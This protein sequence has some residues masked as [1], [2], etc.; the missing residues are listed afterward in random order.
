[1]SAPQR[2]EFD[3]QSNFRNPPE[4]TC[5]VCGQAG[6]T[7]T[8]A[9]IGGTKCTGMA[10]RKG[11]AVGGWVCSVTC[12]QVKA[13]LDHRACELD[14]RAAAAMDAATCDAEDN[15]EDQGRAEAYAAAAEFLRSPGEIR[16]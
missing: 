4:A 14:R 3:P 1:M 7:N 6:S 10:S 15:E 11:L 2:W 5:W 8:G 16:S 13:T 9:W 12:H